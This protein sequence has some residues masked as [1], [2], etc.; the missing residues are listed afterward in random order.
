MV[1]PRAEGL[2]VGWQATTI[3]ARLSGLLQ[4]FSQKTQPLSP[5]TAYALLSALAVL[6]D[7]GDRRATAVQT[8]EIFKDVRK[9]GATAASV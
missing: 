9:I 8:S 2:P 1:L 6:V 3:A 5:V 7:M 4:M